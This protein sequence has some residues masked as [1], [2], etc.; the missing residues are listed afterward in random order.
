[1]KNRLLRIDLAQ[2]KGKME[3]V[4]KASVQW[5]DSREQLADDLTKQKTNEGKIME[6]VLGEE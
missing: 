4:V 2:I 6:D 5:I 1:M 3:R